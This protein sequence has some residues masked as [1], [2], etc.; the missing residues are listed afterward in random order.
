MKFS[1]GKFEKND[2]L[3]EQSQDVLKLHQEIELLR[4]TLSKFVGSTENLD[5]MLRYSISSLIGLDMDIL[6]KLMFMMR[7]QPYV[8][9]VER[10]D[11]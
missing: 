6:E 5:K 3:K 7:K 2:N 4:E 1:N 8:I 10:L 9:Y 11:I